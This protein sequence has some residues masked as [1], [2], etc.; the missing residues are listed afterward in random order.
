[1]AD[2]ILDNAIM[3]QSMLERLKVNQKQKGVK[4]S[5]RIKKLIAA[6]LSDFSGNISSKSK[7]EKIIKT[8]NTGLKPAFDEQVNSLTKQV[9]Q[10]ALQLANIEYMSFTQVFD[11]DSVNEV[12]GDDLEKALQNNPL[13]LKN[14]NGPLYLSQFIAAWGLL[15]LTQITNTVT[16]TFAEN[17]S[18]QTLS[19]YL[20]NDNVVGYSVIS[21]VANDYDAIA[22]T[23]LQ[24]AHS[25][26][27]IEFYKANTDIVDKEE[28]AAIL[29]SKTSAACR[30]LDGT[31]YPVGKGPR[32]PLHLRCRSRMLPV[33]NNC[34]VELL[35]GEPFKQSVYGEE[36][37]YQ[38]LERQTTKRQDIVL[39]PTRGRLFREGGLSPEQF[40]KLQLHKNFQPMT[41]EEMKQLAPD[42]FER[43]GLT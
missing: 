31:T 38:W 32:P 5:K 24:H 29:D 16:R 4:S 41:L 21:K 42:A 35:G 39:G 6:S 43:A 27:T 7:A 18:I 23:A 25:I 15:S 8:L 33:I 34:Y 28:F 37:Y 40:A 9:N 11:A 36:T 1:M 2:L 12:N 3:A 19:N 17:G 13:S 10:S 22:S 20:Y 14:W 26:S 30:A